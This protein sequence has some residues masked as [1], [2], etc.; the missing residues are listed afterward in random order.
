MDRT[1]LIAGIVL[2]LVISVC[3]VAKEKEIKQ[4]ALPPAVQQA[5][6]QQSAGEAVMV[7]GYTKDKVE[8]DVIYRMN[9]VVEGRTRGIVMGADGTVLAVV[10]E[11]SWD[12][13]PASVQTDFTNV[14]GKGTYGAVSTVTKE[15]KVEAYRAVLETNGKRQHVQVKPN[16]SALEPIPTSDSKK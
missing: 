9:L 3:A 14:A 8:G 10:Q 16:A 1:R 2:G 13:L 11:I 15:G 12:E 6:Q 5:A 4:S 7:T